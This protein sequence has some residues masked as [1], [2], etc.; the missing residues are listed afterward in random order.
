MLPYQCKTVQDS[1]RIVLLFCKE[2]E[3]K[4]CLGSIADVDVPIVAV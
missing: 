1:L 3:M 2:I 4:H